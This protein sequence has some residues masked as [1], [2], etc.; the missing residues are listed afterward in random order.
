LN[1]LVEK[2][3]SFA[4]GIFEFVLNQAQK[5]FKDP[6]KQKEAGVHIAEVFK[7][8]N[9]DPLYT[10]RFIP[11]MQVKYDW[12]T[13]PLKTSREILVEFYN[14]LDGQGVDFEKKWLDTMLLINTIHWKMEEFDVMLDILQKLSER[15][16]DL[17]LAMQFA[18][19]FHL[20][21]Y[22][23]NA[24]VKTNLGLI[25]QFCV[26]YHK[27]AINFYRTAHATFAES[28]K[29][30][31]TYAPRNAT[32]QF[33]MDSGGSHALA[34]SVEYIPDAAPRAFMLLKNAS[35]HAV[36]MN[37]CTINSTSD[38]ITQVSIELTKELQTT[39][40]SLDFFNLYERL[41]FNLVLNELYKV[42]LRGDTSDR[43]QLYIAVDR[44]VKESSMLKTMN[45][46]SRGYLRA[47]FIGDQINAAASK[48]SP[49]IFGEIFDYHVAS[50]LEP[51][52]GLESDQQFHTHALTFMAIFI[53]YKEV[54]RGLRCAELVTEI[55]SQYAFNAESIKAELKIKAKNPNADPKELQNL[56]KLAI[57]AIEKQHIEKAIERAMKVP[58]LAKKATNL[59]E[60]VNMTK[61]QT[62]AFRRLI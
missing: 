39:L 8:L 2:Y 32:R 36:L 31:L 4:V 34:Q 46:M 60:L 18:V 51:K 22:I 30:Q 15:N 17:T 56:G 54:E 9:N 19:V 16:L 61:K 7:K 49:K 26:N 62:K 25:Q 41:S 6:E 59:L 43:D 28:D 42:Y 1:C 50:L 57:K 38:P 44:Y 13:T 35:I 48:G 40:F 23:G 20:G 10:L 5:T 53:K 55:L 21:N 33:I 45:P 14:L 27:F 3:S 24:S 12:V 47:I 37:L 52:W 11:D 58:H 29:K